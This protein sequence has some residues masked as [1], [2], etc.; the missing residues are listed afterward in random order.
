MK[1]L[2]LT[3][4]ALLLLSLLTPGRSP[5]RAGWSGHRHQQVQISAT[6]SLL[7]GSMARRP[8]TMRGHGRGG[9]E[10]QE[11]QRTV[12]TL[13]QNSPQNTLAE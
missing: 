8:S 12:V 9:Q 7:P 3:V 2:L 6:P 13:S 11:E 10:K 1:L 4:A 5:F